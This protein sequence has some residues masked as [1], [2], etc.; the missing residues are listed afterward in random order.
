MRPSKPARC[1]V[2]RQLSSTLRMMREKFKQFHLI[3]RSELTATTF[4]EKAFLMTSAE[5][6]MLKDR[7]CN[8]QTSLFRQVRLRCLQVHQIPAEKILEWEPVRPTFN[9][10]WA[11]KFVKKSRVVKPMWCQILMEWVQSLTQWRKVS[12]WLPHRG[13]AVVG[14]IFLWWRREKVGTTS[15]QASQT[16]N[17][18]FSGSLSF[19]IQDQDW[20]E[21]MLLTGSA[22]E[23]SQLYPLLVV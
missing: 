22:W 12:S 3:K 7:R 5:F 23:R 14:T 17:L 16:R 19:Q 11:H 15:W 9:Q 4:L 2:P 8:D 6:W 13:Q 21:L 18:Y 10:S 20:E 1:G